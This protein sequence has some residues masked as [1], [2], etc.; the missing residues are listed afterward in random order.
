MILDLGI[1]V[2]FNAALREIFLPLG[3]EEVV[4]F[5]LNHER[6]Q[7][8]IDNACLQIQALEQRFR[9]KTDM[10]KVDLLVRESAKIFGLA[11]IKVRVQQN[12]SECEKIRLRNEADK[13]RRIDSLMEEARDDE[14][15]AE[16]ADESGEGRRT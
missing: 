2:K 15:T 11:A 9:I 14:E 8:A 16:S 7:K 13:Q 12:A 3:G 6:K 1:L 5:L 4:T 10:R